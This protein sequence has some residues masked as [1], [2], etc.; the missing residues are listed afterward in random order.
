MSFKDKLSCNMPFPIADN[1]TAVGIKNRQLKVF[2]YQII[3]CPKCI[4]DTQGIFYV[5][6]F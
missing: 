6:T 3:V 1:F 2:V 4:C 5:N